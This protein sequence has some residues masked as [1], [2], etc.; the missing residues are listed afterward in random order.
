MHGTGHVDL[1]NSETSLNQTILPKEKS[2][3]FNFFP[4]TETWVP[5]SYVQVAASHKTHLPQYPVRSNSAIELP[6]T[7]R[8]QEQFMFLNETTKIPCHNDTFFFANLV[9]R[10][11][12]VLRSPSK[13]MECFLFFAGDHDLRTVLP[14]LWQHLLELKEITCIDDGVY[15]HNPGGLQGGIQKKKPLEEKI[16]EL[17]EK[18]FR[19]HDGLRQYNVPNEDLD[20]KNMYDKMDK[21]YSKDG[22]LGIEKRIF[23]KKEESMDVEEKSFAP[24]SGATDMSE[25]NNLLND[26]RYLINELALGADRAEAQRARAK[27]EEEQRGAPKAPEVEMKEFPTAMQVVDPNAPSME[28]SMRRM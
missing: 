11:A 9:A 17:L 23:I 20:F 6:T 5:D 16:Y 2:F 14:L 15:L 3:T 13:G 28:E 10:L 18:N 27:K 25:T 12:S 21:E 7:E 24:P 22:E 1:F 4:V 8:P 19:K 26:I